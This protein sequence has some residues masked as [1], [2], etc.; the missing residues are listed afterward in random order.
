LLSRG[1]KEDAELLCVEVVDAV[2]VL[3]GA[4]SQRAYEAWRRVTLPELD[5]A[6]EDLTGLS[7]KVQSDY[8]LSGKALQS[9]VIMVSPLAER[10][11]NYDSIFNIIK[12]SKE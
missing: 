3:Y 9:L 5:F 4:L 7:T 8:M 12:S 1:Y 2:D 6:E 10:I 11:K